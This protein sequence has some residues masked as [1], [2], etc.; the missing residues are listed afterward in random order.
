MAVT[1]GG[2]TPYTE[3]GF[4][5]VSSGSVAAATMTGN[6]KALVCVLSQNAASPETINTVTYNSADISGNQVSND[7]SSFNSL[8][9]YVVTNPTSGANFAVTLAALVPAMVLMTAYFNGVAQTTSS[10]TPSVAGD[11]EPATATA[12]VDV[13]NSQSEDLIVGIATTNDLSEANG[14]TEARLGAGQTFIGQIADSTEQ[15]QGA[16]CYESG[17]AGTVTVSWSKVGTSGWRIAAIPLIAIAE[18]FVSGYYV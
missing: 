13:T 17:A 5:G 11:A 16:M 7:F 4:N 9:S 15:S 6:N 1:L 14:Y 12:T 18:F 8:T 3:A 10:R 2:G